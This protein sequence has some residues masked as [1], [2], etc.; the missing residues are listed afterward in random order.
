ML[1]CEFTE[2]PLSPHFLPQNWPAAGGLE[3]MAG[4]E[5]G[6]WFTFIFCMWS[7]N[8]KWGKTSEVAAEDEILLETGSRYIDL[9]WES[10]PGE[11]GRPSF[12]GHQQGFLQA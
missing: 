5:V 9:G 7:E 4:T 12:H 6:F 1:V 10:P 3:E 2:F 8:L 11:E